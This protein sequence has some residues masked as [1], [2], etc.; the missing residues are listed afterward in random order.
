MRLTESARHARCDWDD[1]RDDG[2][3]SVQLIG[4]PKSESA[5][6]HWGT[7]R[8]LDNLMVHYFEIAEQ[9]VAPLVRIEWATGGPVITL[10]WLGLPLIAM[11][12]PTLDASGGRRAIGVPIVGGVFS[13]DSPRARLSI[14]LTHRSPEICAL[15]EL[16]GYRPRG[17]QSRILRFLFRHVQAWL[18]VRVG[19]RFLQELADAWTGTN[20]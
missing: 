7:A 16:D 14:I 19:R 12:R 8:Q 5:F 3:R 6:E 15:V 20:T 18:H 2:V 1:T 13:G 10:R 11:G 9:S 4:L 17:S